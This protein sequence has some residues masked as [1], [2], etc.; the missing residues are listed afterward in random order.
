MRGIDL[1][2][3][4]FSLAIAHAVLPDK[5][6]QT[7]G[8][9][10]MINLHYWHAQRQEGHHPARRMRHALQDRTGEYRARD[11]FTKEFLEMNPN[12]RMPVM[13]DHQPRRWQAARG[14]R[15]GRHS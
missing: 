9:L 15:V 2:D 10:P 8:G 12:H 14:I 4:L 7:L 11:Q 1:A 5:L 13:V 6:R 3:E